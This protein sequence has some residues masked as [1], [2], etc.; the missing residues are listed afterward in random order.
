MTLLG[1]TPFR[2]M[3]NG[4][5]F[6]LLM[7]AANFLVAQ[8]LLKQHVD[9]PGQ[10]AMDQRATGHDP[11]A[12]QE[13]IERAGPSGDAVV[14]GKGI[15]YHNGPVL[16]SNPVPIYIIWYG[17]WSGTGSNT[18]ATVSLVEHFISTLGNTPYEKIATTYGDTT[19]NVSGN[20]SF[21]GATFVSSTTNL[22]D[23]RLKT[24]VSNAITSGALPNNPNG[25]YLV[26]TSSNINETSG[27]C[28]QYCGFHTHATIS[29]SDIKYAFVG[30]PDRCPSGCEIQ[31]TGPNSPATG[32]GGADG[33]ID[34]IAH[35]HFEAITD[36]DLNAWFDSSGEEDSDKCNFNFGTTSTCTASSACSASGK[37]ASAKFNVSFGGND[38]MIQQQWENAAG[39]KCVLH[40]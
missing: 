13:T 6:L 2:R 38:W 1:K 17:N 10:T 11:S 9:N 23:S 8:K 20:V 24:T 21:A 27:F 29:G 5:A 12:A 7:L 36:P 33:M 37:A 18:A 26:L 16:K 35:E 14:T 30:N 39:G 28:T 15:N 40:L 31:T 3:R 34:V 4:L 19:G 32:V 25:V 22:S